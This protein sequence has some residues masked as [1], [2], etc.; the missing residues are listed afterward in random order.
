[1]NLS[2]KSCIGQRDGFIPALRRQKQGDLNEFED[3]LVLHK[4]FQVQDTKGYI[5]RPCLQKQTVI[6]Q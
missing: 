5:E 6:T 1:M 4:K 3:C 2:E